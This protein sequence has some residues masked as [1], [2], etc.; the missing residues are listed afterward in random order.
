METLKIKETV[1]LTDV[2]IAYIKSVETETNGSHK[3]V[4][5][6][7][8]NSELAKLGGKT[9]KV[10]FTNSSLIEQ[11]DAIKASKETVN[12]KVVSFEASEGKSESNYYVQS[13]EYNEEITNADLQAIKNAQAVKL[14]KTA[15]LED[16]VKLNL[17]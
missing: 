16:M 1:T 8:A 15:S 5:L 13:V 6:K 17:I 14:L 7:A 3:I 9:L 4:S 10:A 12:L 2:K 11:L